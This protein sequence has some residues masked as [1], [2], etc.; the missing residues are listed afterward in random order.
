MKKV[1]L[2]CLLVAAATFVAVTFSQQGEAAK[3]SGLKG[4][5][6]IAGH[7]GHL[8]VIDL[9]TL[10]EPTDLEKGRIVIS[11][12]GS[13]MEGV[14]AGMQFE[15]VKKGGGTHGG[16][17]TEGKLVVG[18]LNGNV[19]VHDMKTG[20]NSKPMAVGKKFCDAIV[21][22][23]GN[24]Y[25]EDMADG[26]VYVWDPK[27]MKTVDKIPVG[28][29]VCGIAW[30]KNAD[31]AYVSDMPQGKIFVLDWKTKKTIKEISDPEMTFIHQIKMA[32]DGH[33]LWVSAPNE[34]DPGLKPPTHKSQIV[35]IDTKKDEVV[36]HIVLPDGVFPHD[37]EFSP[38]GKTA[39]LAS[40]TY[41]A[42]S[43][44]ILMDYKT[45]KVT[46]RVSACE[47]CHKQY[48]IEVKIDKGSP[49]LCGIEVA[50][51]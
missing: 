36:D 4:T 34:F 13:E 7:G 8:A 21:G 38:D 1:L 16:A 12:A 10:K 26:H 46:E 39:L 17:L 3:G 47:A 28:A 14:I 30:T 20:K 15:E 43:E 27:G 6:F 29:S 44:L 40:R 33:S 11:E 45:K 31:K 24:I 23:D 19:V 49:L 9:A 25:L 50:W 18:L 51:K 5:A 35:V 2:I 22:P 48:G 41:G 32:P 42:D 37:F